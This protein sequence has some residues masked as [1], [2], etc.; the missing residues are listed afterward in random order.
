MYRQGDVLLVELREAPPS[1]QRVPPASDGVVVLME[2]DTTGHRH[3]LI[4]PDV[5]FFR[6]A[7]LTHDAANLF[8]GHVYVGD[9]DAELRHE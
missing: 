2:G 9:G 4:G 7:G 1:G 5:V 8:L 3:A 6:D